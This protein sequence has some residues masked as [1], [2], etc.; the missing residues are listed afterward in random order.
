MTT[1]AG[2]GA[3]TAFM[4]ARDL[5]KALLDDNWRDALSKYD[6]LLYKRGMIRYGFKF[7]MF[8]H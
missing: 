2:L 6:E 4:D 3:N 5:A 7:V 1:H 8:L